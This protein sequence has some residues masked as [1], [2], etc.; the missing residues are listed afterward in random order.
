MWQNPELCHAFSPTFWL[1]FVFLLASGMLAAVREATHHGPWSPVHSA[2]CAKNARP[3]L[4][5]PRSFLRIVSAASSLEGWGEVS[6]PKHGLWKW[7]NLQFSV[8][9]LWCNPLGGQAS[10]M[11]PFYCPHETWGAGEI[12]VNEYADILATAFSM[13][14]KV[15]SLWPWRIVSS[16]RIYE[17]GKLGGVESQTLTI[18]DSYFLLIRFR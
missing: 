15:V 3:W 11:G 16:A 13:S 12:N 8:L 17:T 6:L 5:L 18:L 7:L 10:N 14:N 1:T 4:I 9:L 2:G